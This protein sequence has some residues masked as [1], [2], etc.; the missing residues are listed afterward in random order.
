MHFRHLPT[1]ELQTLTWALQV[2]RRSEDASVMFD[3]GGY[4]TRLTYFHEWSVGTRA[5]DGVLQLEYVYVPPDFRHREWFSRYCQMCQLLTHG[6]FVIKSPEN[7]ILLA[8]MER[9]D[10]ERVA[11]DV[12]ATFDGVARERPFPLNG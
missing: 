8:L 10:F 9:W 7:P 3:Q 11:P 2:M 4:Q 6:A 5:A 1:V 12:W